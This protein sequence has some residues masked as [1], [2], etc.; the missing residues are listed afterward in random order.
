MFDVRVT[1][2][3]HL[4]TIL[5]I[6]SCAIAQRKYYPAPKAVLLNHTQPWGSRKI[7]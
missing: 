4:S 7:S 6:Q 3:Q 1:S 5:V 2:N